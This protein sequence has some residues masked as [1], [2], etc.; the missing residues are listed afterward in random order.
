[1]NN[2]IRMMRDEHRS[3]TAVLHGL[4]HLARSA[5]DPALRPRF[6]V[7]R[8]M[9]HYIDAFPERLHHP[10]EEAYLFARLVE[11]AP[12]SLPLVERL[13]A[14]HVEGAE[15]IRSLA[16]LLAEFE[17]SW[18]RG[19]RAFASAIDDYAAF[20]WRHMR[21]EE[22]ELLPLAERALTAED[23]RAIGE[24][25]AGDDD[26]IADLREKDFSDLFSRI[27]SLAPEPIGLGARWG[28]SAPKPS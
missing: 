6:E 5:L 1:V 23:W 9:I 26:P 28:K 15:R 3:I 27:V 24:A 16:R 17:V 10:K 19:A 8:A 14:E 21:A 7:F 20:H 25:F 22:E 12:A 13:R 2:A 4:Q 18:P 11:R